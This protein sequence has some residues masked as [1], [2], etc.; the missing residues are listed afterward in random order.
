MFT[1]RLRGR[2]RAW[3]IALTTVAGL[4]LTAPVAEASFSSTTMSTGG[5]NPFAV[6]SADFNGDG[7][8]DV[9]DVSDASGKLSV[10]L[11]TTLPG[12]VAPTFASARQFN[13]GA[14]SGLSLAV[15][16][17]NLDG[18]PDVVAVGISADP[19]FF[20]SAT[21]PGAATPQF[22]PSTSPISVTGPVAVA[23]GDLNGDGEP[24]VA[25]ANGSGV[26]V[27]LNE[28]T[29]GTSTLSFGAANSVA[30]S[31]NVGGLA[32][33]DL[34]NDGVPDI[35]GSHGNS[36]SVI[37]N[38]TAAGDTTM[39]FGTPTTLT[40]GGTSANGVQTG[41]F[42]GDGRPDIA[43]AF[44][45]SGGGSS[46]VS[47]F[48]N[49]TATN[50]TSL[51]F[52]SATTIPPLGTGD[53]GVAVGDFNGDGRADIAVADPSS[54]TVFV[55]LNTTVRAPNRTRSPRATLWPTRSI[56]RP[57]LRPTSMATA[58]RT[59]SRGRSTA[60]RTS[61]S[62]RTRARRS[63]TRTRP[64]SGWAT[65][66]PRPSSTQRPAFSGRAGCSSLSARSCIP[67]SNCAAITVREKFAPADSFAPESSRAF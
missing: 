56:P 44:T 50:A 53:G 41:D 49:T 54:G 4:G 23:V 36:V 66:R 26:S 33:A 55:L 29:P 34:N 2:V 67:R 51:S 39:T 8:P 35:A 31:G 57:W 12:S 25:I 15:G 60:H 27:Y 61:R 65:S 21:V 37:P 6:V 14:A 45:S 7:R 9:A 52:G 46:G 22:A 63:R 32:I 19:S 47:V 42:N 24:D 20:L 3:A 58:S 11:N 18:Q 48:S 59:C 28:T 17:F 64:R 10:S 16:D 62:S 43:V 5:V 13:S 30:L 40:P 38:L 1:Q